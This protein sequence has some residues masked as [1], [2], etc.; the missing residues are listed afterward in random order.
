VTAF[1]EFHPKAELPSK[2][3]SAPSVGKG[4]G[5]LRS[6]NEEEESTNGSFNPFCRK[7]PYVLRRERIRSSTQDRADP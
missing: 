4:G 7:R 2:S 6:L 3:E 5:W 1:P